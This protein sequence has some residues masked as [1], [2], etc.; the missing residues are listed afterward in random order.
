MTDIIIKN[1]LIGYTGEKLNLIQINFENADGS[2]N[3]DIQEGT[4]R[5]WNNQNSSLTEE[6]REM[7]G[8]PVSSKQIKK[9]SKKSQK[10]NLGKK[11]KRK[12]DKNGKNLIIN[13]NK[14]GKNN[15]LFKVFNEFKSS[16]PLY[17]IYPQ[18]NYIEKNLKNNLYSSLNELV[19]EIRNTFSQIFFSSIETEKYN[20]IYNLCES[21]EKIYKEYDN[22]MFLKESKNLHDI[23]NK[24]KKELRQTEMI[25]N[26]SSI[27][28]IVNNNSFYNYNDNIYNNNKNKFKFHF[29]DSEESENI[30]DVTT[31]KYKMLISNKINKLNNDQKKGIRSI[32]SSNCLLDKNSESNVIKVDVNKMP[33]NQ[34]KQLE[35]YVNKCIK[36]NNKNYN[37]NSNLSLVN[38]DSCASKLNLKNLGYSKFG[39]VEEEKEMDILKN[40]DLSSE[41][42]DD[43][44]DDEED[45]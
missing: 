6:T 36:E 9:V 44:D 10:Q 32:V 31:K 30:S 27:N 25:R 15:L 37:F 12:T 20:K 4:E 19:N 23:I 24:L 11:T 1:P 38:N 22:K 41:L 17:K 35:K 5:P 14:N 18:F 39:L 45:E 3:L 40:D 21:F 26:S 34:L 13:K 2:T 42:S 28:S 16:S 33:Y 7:K 29:N 43:E 8:R